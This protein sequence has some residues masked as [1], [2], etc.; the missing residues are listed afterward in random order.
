[1]YRIKEINLDTLSEFLTSI[2]FD[3]YDE[4]LSYV[5]EYNYYSINIKYEIVEF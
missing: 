4:A 1:M 5:N 3:N 2:T